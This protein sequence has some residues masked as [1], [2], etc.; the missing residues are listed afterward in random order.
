MAAPATLG[1]QCYSTSE[2]EIGDFIQCVYEC[3]EL[4]VAGYFSQ[5]GVKDP[6]FHRKTITRI[7]GGSPTTVEED[8]DY[9]E[10]PTTPATTGRGY[11]YLLKADY[12]LLIADRMVQQQISWE[13][14]NKRNYIYGCVFDAANAKTEE[15]ITINITH[16]NVP[17]DN[18][19]YTAGTVDETLIDQ[20]EDITKRFLQTKSTV[21]EIENVL[22]GD[23]SVSSKNITI[24]ETITSIKFAAISNEQLPDD[25]TTETDPDAIINK[26]TGPTNMF[27]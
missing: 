20:F 5:L 6:K 27:Y 12:G 22:A 17:A 19:D 25:S 13:A 8:I 24:T 15:E 10:L 7:D 16:K 21:T 2:M 4:N 1:K 11:F 9:E 23:G 18:T 14:L 3:T 26:I